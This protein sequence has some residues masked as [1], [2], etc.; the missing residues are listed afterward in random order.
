MHYSNK[1]FIAPYIGG[2]AKGRVYAILSCNVMTISTMITILTMMTIPTMMTILT[3]MT[4][5]T[6]MTIVF[7]S[8]LEVVLSH[9]TFNL[10]V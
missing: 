5:S 3:M 10:L 6:M 4:I 7:E 2:V 1:Q 8:K 9:I